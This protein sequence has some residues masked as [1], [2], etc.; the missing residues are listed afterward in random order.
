ML[1]KEDRFIVTKV[2]LYEQI[3]GLLGGR[4]A[5]EIV[6][7]SQ[8]TGASNDFQQA[9]QIAR[10]MVTEYG[11]SD[12]GPIQYEGNSKVFIGRDYGQRHLI[13]NK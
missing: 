1:P 8:S 2:E 6:F 5:E 3:V 9:T 13:P 12:L 4:V 11:M 10:S 7:N